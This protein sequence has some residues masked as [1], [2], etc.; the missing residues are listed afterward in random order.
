M[1]MPKGAEPGDA[2]KGGGTPAARAGTQPQAP[3]SP[4]SIA[5]DPNQG[6]QAAAKVKMTDSVKPHDRPHQLPVSEKGSEGG[7]PRDP[8]MDRSV[9]APTDADTAKHQF[10]RPGWISPK[11]IGADAASTAMVKE[12]AASE[13]NSGSTFQAATQAAAEAKSVQPGAASN[14]T[15]WQPR[16]AQG[17][18]MS[19]IVDRAVMTLKRGQ[20]EMKLLLKPELLGNLRMRVI[21]E[22]H[23]VTVRIIAETPVVREVIESNL[24]QLKSDLHNSGLEVDAFDVKTSA[25][26]HREGQHSRHLNPFGTPKGRKSERAPDESGEETDSMTGDV[27]RDGTAGGIDYFA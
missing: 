9:E 4:E 7:E 19:Q 11:E 25:D 8:I 21:T 22:N 2:G 26:S 10:S 12:S 3:L 16:T 18:L 6:L 15:Q 27:H 17:D 14:D 23:H 13:S 24:G 20:S 5:T 1:D